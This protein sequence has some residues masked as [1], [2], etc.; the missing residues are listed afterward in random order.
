MSLT[1]TTTNILCADNSRPGLCNRDSTLVFAGVYLQSHKDSCCDV[2]S[3]SAIKP[4]DVHLKQRKWL[5]LR[6]RKTSSL[7]Y[8]YGND[9]LAGVNAVECRAVGRW[10][11]FSMAIFYFIF[12]L[13]FFYC[14]MESLVLVRWER[15]SLGLECREQV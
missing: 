13:Y 7:C 11:E 6:Y 3:D 1:Y 14:G 4:D 9:V 5:F 8:F 2:Q 12:F 15:R 10:F